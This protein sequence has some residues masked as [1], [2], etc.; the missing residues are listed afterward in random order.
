MPNSLGL[1]SPG[2]PALAVYV[3]K[4]DLELDWDQYRNRLAKRLQDLA[5]QEQDPEYVLEKEWSDQ[6]GNS[7]SLSSKGVP[8]AVDSEEFHD[9]LRER[10]NL[11]PENFPLKVRPDRDLKAEGPPSNL[12]EWVRDLK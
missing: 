4:D 3:R 9:L 2:V 8:S 11:R 1:W 7:L 5:E 10:H 6:V 12:A